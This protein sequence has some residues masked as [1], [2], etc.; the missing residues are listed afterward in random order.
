MFNKFF[1]QDIEEDEY[2]EIVEEKPAYRVK[3]HPLEHTNEV[4]AVANS[5]M[6]G[7]VVV[8]NMTECNNINYALAFLEGAVHA[9]HGNIKKVARDTYLLT[10]QHIKCDDLYDFQEIK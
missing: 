2:E 9:L 10:P 7:C 4:S 3:I 1:R 5:L 6:L 8:V